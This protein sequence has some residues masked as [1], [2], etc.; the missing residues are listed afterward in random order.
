MNRTKRYY[1]SIS[2]TNIFTVESS[3]TILF[4]QYILNILDA[5]W[6]QD[7][8]KFYVEID[9]LNELKAQYP[10]Y[11]YTDS[12]N[13]M[14]Q[15][16]DIVRNF[17]E[18]I[19]DLKSQLNNL[20][21]TLANDTKC[22]TKISMPETQIIQDTSIK[23]EYMQYLLMFDINESRG[24]FLEANLERAREVLKENG[25]R[26]RRYDVPLTIIGT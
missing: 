18:Q 21:E 1:N 20:E 9:K 6:L 8:V 13:I 16:V 2:N 4:N 14:V 17:R 15:L 12:L 10:N 23:L 22:G 11:K 24:I 3:T 19:V 5:I 26:L 25:F 7:Y